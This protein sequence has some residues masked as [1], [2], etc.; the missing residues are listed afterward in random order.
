[1]LTV[2]LNDTTYLT[3]VPLPETSYVPLKVDILI[4]FKSIGSASNSY[5]LLFTS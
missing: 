5:G 3:D 4:G 2:I 1:M